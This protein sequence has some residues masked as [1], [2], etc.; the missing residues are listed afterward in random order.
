MSTLQPQNQTKY[1]SKFH[2]TKTLILGGTSGIG[3]A[4]AEGALEHGSSVIISSSTTAKLSSALERLKKSYPLSVHKVAGTTCDLSVSDEEL[5][6][7]LKGLFD[8]AI[9]AVD[10]GKKVG[11]VVFTA[12]D[13]GESVKLEGLTPAKFWATLRVRCLG[14]A[15][16]AKVADQG[17]MEKSD[18]SSFT[19]TG[20]T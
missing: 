14:A 13:A 20:G 12:G 5:E 18:K 7:Q 6:G 16:A 3:Y 9:N 11:H 8:F 10:Q 15:M 19:L 4:V 2:D 1:T 17:Y